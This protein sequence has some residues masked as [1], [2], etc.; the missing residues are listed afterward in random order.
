MFNICIQDRVFDIS[1][2]VL[3]GIWYFEMAATSAML[4]HFFA[5]V[6]LTLSLVFMLRIVLYL[7]FV[8]LIHPERTRI[9]QVK[10]HFRKKK[11]MCGVVY[12]ILLICW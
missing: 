9:D 12:L 3:L 8:L 5:H 7:D 1:D 11:L 2:D 10:Y 6:S 4:R